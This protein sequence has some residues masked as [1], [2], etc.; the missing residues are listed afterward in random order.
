MTNVSVDCFMKRMDLTTWIQ[1]CRF[2]QHGLATALFY[3]NVAMTLLY[4]ITSINK[5]YL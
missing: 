2:Q 3:N 4:R 1:L 5:Y